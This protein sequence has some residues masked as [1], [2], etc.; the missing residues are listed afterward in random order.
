MPQSLMNI[1]LDDD[2]VESLDALARSIEDIDWG[3]TNR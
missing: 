1:R 3:S 2:I